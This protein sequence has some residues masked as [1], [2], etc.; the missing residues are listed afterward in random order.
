MN[1]IRTSLFD[2]FKVR[3]GPSSS[4]TIGPM[5]A[6]LLGQNPETGQ[7]MSNRYK[8]TSQDGL[9]VCMVD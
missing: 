3:P 5:L 7:N 9:A 1:G 8:E 2:L 6:G 4:H